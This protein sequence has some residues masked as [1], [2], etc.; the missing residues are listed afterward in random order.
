MIRLLAAALF[1]VSPLLSA[2]PSEVPMNI[3]LILS[4]DV[5]AETVGAYGGES[6]QTPQLDRLA[7]DGI[8]FDSRPRPAPVHAF[9]GQDHD[10]AAQLSQ[11]PALQ[12]LPRSHPEKTFAHLLRD[13]GYMTRP[14]SVSGSCFNQRFEHVQGALPADAGFDDFLLWQLKNEA[15]GLSLLGTGPQ[16]RRGADNATA[17]TAYGPDLCSTTTCLRP[18]IRAAHR[19]PFPDLL[20]HGAGSRP[21]GDH[22]GHAR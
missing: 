4:D 18:Y 19:R 2:S 1:L 17:K 15:Q 5:G 7:A 9:P 11:L 22:P 20:P 6:Y 16:S 8:R 13:A 14:W 10:R 12:P 21:L 3:I